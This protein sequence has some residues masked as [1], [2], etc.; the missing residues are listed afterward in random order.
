MGKSYE[1]G[2]L[3]EREEVEEGKRCGERE[4]PVTEART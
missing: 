1:E 4:Q 3:D 2:G